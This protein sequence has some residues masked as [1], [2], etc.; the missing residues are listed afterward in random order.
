MAV[1]IVDVDGTLVDSNY[2]H[3]IT[4]QRALRTV[5]HEI[6]AWRIHRHIGMGGDKIIEAVAGASVEREHGDAVREHEGELFLDVIGE[7]APLPG[8]RQLLEGL[9]ERGRRVVL[10]SSAKA[11]EVDHY[12]DVLDAREIVDGWTTSADVERTKPD[13]DLLKAAMD[14]ARADGELLIGDS[15][16]DC[17]AA[18]KV[19]VETIGLLSGGYAASELY[20]A[21]AR[22]VYRDAE[23]LAERL[24]SALTGARREGA[25]PRVGGG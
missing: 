17:L 7:V 22:A 21:G 13:P 5:G 1:V 20:D 9:H 15:V 25:S 19:D 24:D 2:L 12:L 3:A 16:W 4:W 6:P 18:G 23:D 8:A 14:K 10:A 11:H